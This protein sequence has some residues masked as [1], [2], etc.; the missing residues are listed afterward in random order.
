[1]SRTGRVDAFSFM[2]PAANLR[3]PMWIS[4]RRNVPVVSTTAPHSMRWPSPRTTAAIEPSAIDEVDHLA[5]DD[6]K[7]L[8]RVDRRAHRLPVEL[9]IGLGARP[10][11]GRTLAP[12]EQTELDTGR[13]GHAAH[14]R[15]R[16]RRSRAPD[17][18]CRARRS[19]GCRTSRRSCRRCSV[20]SAVA[21]PARAATAAASQPAWPPPIT[22]TSNLCC[23]DPVLPRAADALH[24]STP[25]C[26]AKRIVSVSRETVRHRAH[27]CF[28]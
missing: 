8:L 9:A 10:A 23:M 18:P 5:F 6:R 27:A 17:D 20:T 14:Q 19:P 25:A 22:M 3:S 26:Q 21:A 24:P 2:R 16:A 15:R 11:H 1:M 12:V 28:T 13:V 7:S 4:P